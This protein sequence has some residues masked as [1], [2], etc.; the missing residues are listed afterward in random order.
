MVL[1]KKVILKF[2][3]LDEYVY[4]YIKKDLKDIEEFKSII[5]KR[6]KT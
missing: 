1:F 4:G 6:F 2:Q 3:Q 5:I